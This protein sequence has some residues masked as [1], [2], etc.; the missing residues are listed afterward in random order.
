MPCQSERFQI[1][2]PW[3]Y[4]KRKLPS[5][6]WDNLRF[7]GDIISFLSCMSKSSIVY[8]L[9]QLESIEKWL[10]STWWFVLT[11]LVSKKKQTKLWIV[12]DA[13]HSIVR[14][15]ARHV[16]PGL[17]PDSRWAL[18]VI[19]ATK[20]LELEYFPFIGSLIIHI[21]Q[22]HQSDAKSGKHTFLFFFSHLIYQKWYKLH[23]VKTQLSIHL[24]LNPN[25]L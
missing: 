24:Q 1:Y 11:Q 4:I 3:F 14:V 5:T 6:G 9:L 25:I 23:T 17:E 10:G 2:D 21:K 22:K 20:K 12:V 19:F 15:N 13:Y 7:W 8:S 16:D 18:W